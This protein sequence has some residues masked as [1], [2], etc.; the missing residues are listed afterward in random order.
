MLN[1]FAAAVAVLLIGLLALRIFRF[2]GHPWDKYYPRLAWL[3]ATTYFCGVYLFA[4]VSGALERV[5]TPPIATATQ[6]A[7][8]AWVAYTIGCY[9]FILVAYAG[10]W[11]YYTPVFERPKNTLISAG[12]GVLWGSSQGLL[13]ISVWLLLGKL[14]LPEWGRWL[15]TFLVLG[16]WQPNFHNIWWDHYVA[17]EHD[18][19]MTQKIKALG[20]HIPN[21]IITLTYLTL[22]GN[23]AIFVSCQVIACMSAAIGMRYPAP[24]LAPS[25]LN[26]AKRTA[27]K[28]PRC[29]GYIPADPLTD[30]YTPFYRGWTGR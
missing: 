20:C 21:L 24:W 10:V 1:V 22:H 25:A 16:G 5:L 6:L 17:P 18:T 11:S 28:V 29:T 3:K 2:R 15:A 23:A 8:P 12:F 7:D 30:P 27:A 19:P 4:W 14:G 13:F 26:Y 9:L